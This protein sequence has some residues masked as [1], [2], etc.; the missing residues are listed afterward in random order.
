MRKLRNNPQVYKGIKFASRAERR[1]YQEL[2]LLMMAGEIFDLSVQ[3][4][5]LLQEKFEHKYAGKYRA[6]YYTSDF[7]YRETERPSVIVIEEI[8][9][10]KT[11]HYRLRV[12]LFLYL[13]REID[14]REITKKERP[15]LF[16]NTWSL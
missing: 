8:K 7:R 9:G 2:E 13:N 6:I 3:P 16:D 5:F 4:R 11:I 12:R 14:F 15:D 1:R 10:R